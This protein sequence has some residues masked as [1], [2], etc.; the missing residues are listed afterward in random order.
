MQR[1]MCLYFLATGFFLELSSQ[2]VVQN[3]S[4][5]YQF[6]STRRKFSLL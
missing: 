1:W 5:K 6:G 2:T 4:L 3:A